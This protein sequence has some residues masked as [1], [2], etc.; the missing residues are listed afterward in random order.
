M[1]L[2]LTHQLMDTQDM[3]VFLLL[4]TVLQQAWGTDTSLTEPVLS[5]LDMYL[6]VGLWIFLKN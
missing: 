4:G 3:P 6:V 5:P 2:S 1:C